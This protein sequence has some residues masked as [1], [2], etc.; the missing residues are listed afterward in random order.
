MEM[1]AEKGDFCG[2]LG[3]GDDG[4]GGGFLGALEGG[5]LSFIS[6]RVQGWKE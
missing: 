6:A 1:V 2:F 5:V 4:C 3:G